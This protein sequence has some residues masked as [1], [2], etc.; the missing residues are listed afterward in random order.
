MIIIITFLIL[1]VLSILFFM[2]AKIY[3]KPYPK[4]IE[5]I[6][7]LLIEKMIIEYKKKPG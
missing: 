1:A 2:L 7:D 6:E 3:A 4:H 5:D